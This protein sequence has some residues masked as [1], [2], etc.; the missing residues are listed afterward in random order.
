MEGTNILEPMTIAFL[1]LLFGNALYWTMEWTQTLVYFHA[2]VIAKQDAQ[3]YVGN[4][5]LVVVSWAVLLGACLLF[6]S[7][8]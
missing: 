5:W 3:L 6:I 7:L 8:K 2:K 4:V 1:V